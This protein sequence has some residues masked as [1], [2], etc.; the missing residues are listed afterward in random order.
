[1]KFSLDCELIERLDSGFIEELEKKYLTNEI[2][3]IIEDEEFLS[4]IN[5]F[6]AN[7]LNITKTSQSAFMHRNTLVY[8]LNKIKKLSGLDLRNFEDATTFKM[9]ICIYEKQKAKK[10]E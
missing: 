1:M 9:L 2:I 7:D 6:F 8:R 5:A 3:T 4:T 10:G